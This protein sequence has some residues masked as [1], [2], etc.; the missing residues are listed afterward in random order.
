[1]KK[2][3]EDSVRSSMPNL[4]RPKIFTE[5]FSEENK[6]LNDSL[7]QYKELKMLYTKTGIKPIY[8]FYGL[9]ICMALILIGYFEFYLSLLIATLYPLYISIKTLQSEGNKEDIKQWLT[10]W[11]IYLTKG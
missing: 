7:L 2:Y 10:Y 3:L 4:I 5:Y 1:M 8:F 9:G 11:Y 6:T